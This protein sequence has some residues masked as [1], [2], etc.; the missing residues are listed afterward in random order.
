MENVDNLSHILSTIRRHRPMATI[1]ITLSPMPLNATFEYTSAIIGDC[2]SKSVL[3]VA[4]DEICRKKPSDVHYWPIFEAVRWI[5][6]YTGDVFGADDGS[7]RHVSVHTIEAI[8]SEFV[9]RIS[10]LRKKSELEV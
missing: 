8:T 1:F 4:V 6:G 3:R 7:A 10:I 2:V 9:N 5:G